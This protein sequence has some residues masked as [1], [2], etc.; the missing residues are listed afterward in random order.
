MSELNVESIV[1]SEGI[2][3]PAVTTSTRPS[4]P[5]T[6]AVIF[7]TTIS[8]YERYNGSTWDVVGSTKSASSFAATGGDVSYSNGYK[9]HTFTG[10]NTFT[11][12]SASPGSTVEVLVVGG[13]GAGGGRSGGGGG[14]GGVVYDPNFAVSVQAYTATVGGGAPQTEGT[15]GAAQAG[16]QG[17][18]SS[19]G[20]LVA[21]G[22]GGGGSDPRQNG[23]DGGCGGGGRYGAQGGA[24]TQPSSSQGGYG[25]NGSFGTASTWN[26]GGGGGAGGI[27]DEG[28]DEGCGD[29]GPGL[30]F[31]FTG[32]TICYSGG[33]GGGSHNP[34]NKRGHGGIG[35]GGHGGTPGGYNPGEAGLPNSGGGGGGGSTTSGGTSSSSG[36]SGGSGIVVVRYPIF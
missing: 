35:G 33:G 20:S 36:G 21:Y 23:T 3:V 12:T 1:L 7:N 4:N 26:G 18:N 16:Q 15:N 27:G 9:I 8:N 28:T 30:C 19:F 32:A 24:A 25:F 2:K 13:G 17:V 14:G 34:A 29:G 10:T 11:V 31:D 6:G 5:Q 22:G